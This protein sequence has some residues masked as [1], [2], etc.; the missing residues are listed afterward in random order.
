M[1]TLKNILTAITL[2]LL[3]LLTG[4]ALLGNVEGMAFFD[5]VYI[6]FLTIT[7]VGAAYTPLTPNGKMIIMG[8][9]L[10][11]MGTV[12]YLLTTLA[13]VFIEGKINI[14]F[15]GM[16][17]GLVRMRNEKNHII[18]CGYGKTGKYAVEELKK[19]KA[20]YVIIEIDQEKVKQL[21][22][23]KESVILGSALDQHVLEKANVKK[24]NVLVAC[25]PDDSDN[26]YLTMSASDM[27]PEILISAKARDEEAV[28]RLHKVG[29]Q[30]VVL[31][32]IVGGKQL[33]NAILEV[34]K[35]NHLSTISQKGKKLKQEETK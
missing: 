9:I 6:T 22:E 5:S 16:K 32:E 27:N 11:G 15:S 18:I 10:F 3:L 35:S 30:I 28:A 29:A 21:L 31:P 12:F 13:S 14:L 19:E 2:F 17:G 26:I 25:L 8:I 24:A 33:A 20:K 7:T 1:A 4:G 34:E 23:K